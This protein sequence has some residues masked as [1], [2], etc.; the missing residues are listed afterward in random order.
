[1][2]PV[3]A[4]EAVATMGLREDVRFFRAQGKGEDRKRQVS[5]IDEGT[6]WKLEKQF[7]SIDRATIKAQIILEGEVRLSQL[8]GKKLTFIDGATL[9]LSTARVPCF[10][11]DLIAP[12][13][14]SA[15]AN[16]NQG[17]L[18]RVIATGIIEV[19]DGVVVSDRNSWT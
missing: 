9:E 8:I 2:L 16:G 11:M 5:L 18:A 17:A 10:A 15:M 7:G 4:V 1:M 13:V 6:I 12:G 19:G 14:R 3:S